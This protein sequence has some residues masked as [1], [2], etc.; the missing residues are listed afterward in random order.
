MRRFAPE[1]TRWI[2]AFAGMTGKWNGHRLIRKR[3][4]HRGNLFSHG[5]HGGVLRKSCEKS[6]FFFVSIVVKKASTAHATGGAFFN[7]P[8][9]NSR[10]PMNFRHSRE[11]GN[12]VHSFQSEG[13][14][15]QKMRR[16]APECTRWIPAFAGMTMKWNGHLIQRCFSCWIDPDWNRIGR[17]PPDS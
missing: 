6:L 1:C 17:G 5:S 10:S 8:P 9:V 11:R 2:P 3:P 7:Q 12:P 13:L 16:F 14:R 4:D 15:I